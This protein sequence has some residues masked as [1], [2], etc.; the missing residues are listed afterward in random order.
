LIY[1]VK[2]FASFFDRVGMLSLSLSLFSPG[3][4]QHEVNQLSAPLSLAL[5]LRVPRK[6]NNKLNKQF[7][8]KSGDK[9]C[10]MNENQSEKVVS[11]KR[12]VEEER[13]S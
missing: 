7:Q 12:Y 4:L 8:S 11:G 1:S 2:V 9:I 10:R 5:T 3:K 13:E 6:K